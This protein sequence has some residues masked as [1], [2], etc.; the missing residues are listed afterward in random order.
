MCNF[1]FILLDGHVLCHLLYARKYSVQEAK[2]YFRSVEQVKLAIEGNETVMVA[3]LDERLRKVKILCYNSKDRIIS[4][5]SEFKLILTS[6]SCNYNNQESRESNANQHE[7]SADQ[8]GQRSGS[9]ERE[10]SETARQDNGV[11]MLS[12]QYENLDELTEDGFQHD[13][14]DETQQTEQCDETSPQEITAETSMQQGN[15][16]E[17]LNMESLA[18]S[19]LPEPRCPQRSEPTKDQHQLGIKTPFEQWVTEQLTSISESLR[20]IEIA[21]ATN[22]EPQKKASYKNAHT[23]H[24]NAEVS[25]VA[26]IIYKKRGNE[27]VSNNILVFLSCYNAVYMFTSGKLKLFKDLRH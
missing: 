1:I 7:N 3:N 14:S 11:E 26:E 13:N 21:V 16:A 15:D 8:T 19:E 23:S 9:P 4:V 27:S 5:K 18:E 2:L 20:K 25:K 6:T 12:R 10:I 22:P 24:F 17:M